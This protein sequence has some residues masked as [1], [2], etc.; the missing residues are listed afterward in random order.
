MTWLLE[1]RDVGTS[2]ACELLGVP[3]ASYYYEAT[4]RV[5]RPVDPELRG[6]VLALAE[7]R[8]SFGYRRIT[9]M[10]RRQTKR[11]VNEKAVRRVMRKEHLLL[12]PAVPPRRTRVPKHP[13]RQITD[14]P[15][16][17]W[18][19]DLKYVWCGRDGW[20]YLQN[21]VECCT[22]EW[23]GYVFDQRC[24]AQEAIRMLNGIVPGR[25]PETG[26]A[27]GT[28]LRVDNGPCYRADAFVKHARGLGFIVEHIQVRTPED[29]GVVESHHAGIAR[30]YLDLAYFESSEEAAA[31]IAKAWLDH[32]TVKPR[33]RLGWKTP[34]EYY[35]SFQAKRGTDAGERTE[36]IATTL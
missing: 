21:T 6:V 27:P 20:A 11:V 33:Q 7:E 26:L 14:A 16:Q 28:R 8:P 1:H 24:G 36:T 10:V 17:A 3:R 4:P 19:A 31:Y 2:R 30:D 23:L 12:P 29:N 9:A 32:E 25:F 13:G 5:E 15:N 35:E 18:Q 22:S 34:R